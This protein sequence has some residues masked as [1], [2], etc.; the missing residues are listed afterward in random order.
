MVVLSAAICT[1]AGKALISRQFVE[2]TRIRI[3]GLLAA[4][5]KLMGTDM[6]QHT[7]VET[8]SVRY[9]YQP[10]D[11]LYLLLITNRASNIVEDLETLRLLSKVIPNVT[12]VMT[13]VSEDEILEKSFDLL[14]S[15]DEVITAGGYREPITLQQIR[16]NMEMESHEEKLHNMIKISKIE[17]AKDQA[18]AAARAIKDKQKEQ[19]SLGM[20]SGGMEG[21]GGGGSRL[22]AEGAEDGGGGGS[23]AGFS[24]QPSFTDPL[25]SPGSAGGGSS[26]G[27]GRQA[28]KGMSLMPAGAKN[29]AAED[30]LMREDKLAPLVSSAAK[31]SSSAAAE[32]TTSMAVAVAQQP[33][34][35]ALVEKVSATLSRDGMVEVF[36]IKGSL[37]LTAADDDAALCSVQLKAPSGKDNSIFSFNT[38]PKVNKPLY[39]KTGMIQ[40]KDPSKGFPSARP[41]G[42]LK[43]T[44]SGT[45]EDLVP[46]KINCWPEEEARG[47]MNVSIE[48]SM[49]VADME[50]HDVRVCIPLGTT[51]AP[52][53]VSVDGSYKHNSSA[54]EL[55]WEI[56]LIDS[57]NSSGSLEFNI[58]Q[59]NTDS[60][61]PISV[62][63]ASQKLY[64][65][66]EVVSVNAA[67]EGGVPMVYGLTK[68]MSS[69]EYVIN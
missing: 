38:H 4:F 23:D 28:P 35:L 30:A 42:I 46:L 64:C 2:M 15:F 68:A 45:S 65:S 18:I 1:K 66:A 8:E 61:F 37:T 29:K 44:H 13:N 27:R 5:P 14:F 10:M 41:V 24:S 26:A 53:I 49:D 7:F 32:P 34:T 17:S 40:L 52:A 57:S 25:P 60:F 47:Q 62:Q 67:G 63:F 48:Y 33:V 39:E 59:R 16:T 50:L 3:E 58:Q 31:S 22:D 9:V 12:G 21:L 43:W 36:E 11:N 69:E 54:G 20:G 55:M 6:K 56:D 51:A 19:Q